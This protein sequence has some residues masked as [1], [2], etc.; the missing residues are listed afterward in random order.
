MKAKYIPKTVDQKMGYLVEECGEVLSAVGK[1]QRWGFDSFNPEVPP[2]QRERNGE[3]IA[4]ELVDLKRAAVLMEE[5]L[6]FLGFI[7]K[8]TVSAGDTWFAFQCDWCGAV[9]DVRLET[10][11]ESC[12]CPR[13][14]SPMV[15]SGSWAAD[16]NGYG[17]RGSKR[18]AD[19]RGGSE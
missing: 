7:P 16:E 18:V 14:S 4:R 6:R 8:P 9:L 2:E 15:F 12:S 17:S 1:T 3:W 5:A 13:C 10:R 19:K 11:P